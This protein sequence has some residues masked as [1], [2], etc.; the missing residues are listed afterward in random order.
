[1]ILTIRTYGVH[2]VTVELN[3]FAVAFVLHQNVSDFVSFVYQGKL[4]DVL[5]KMIYAYY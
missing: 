3:R 5:T 2:I 4:L 1:M